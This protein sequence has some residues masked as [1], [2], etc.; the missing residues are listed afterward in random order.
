MILEA[1]SDFFK[2]I[3]R[4]FSSTWGVFLLLF[5]Y[6]LWGLLSS[7]FCNL[8]GGASFIHNFSFWMHITFIICFKNIHPWGEEVRVEEL[9]I[10]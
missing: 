9:D 4:L 8:A 5:F 2:Q 7:T 3:Y 1:P 10:G 6:Y